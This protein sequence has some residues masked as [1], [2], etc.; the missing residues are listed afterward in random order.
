MHIASHHFHR[1][2]ALHAACLLCAVSSL[3]FAASDTDAET[4]NT[5][6][7][8]E[9]EMTNAVDKATSAF[10]FV[11]YGSGI[12]ISPDGYILSNHHVA[13][14]RSQW[15]VRVFGTRKYY[16]CDLAGTDPVGDLCLLKAR[17][18][19]KLPYVEFGE[20]AALKVGQQCFTIGD[21]FKLADP[22]DGPPAVSLGTIS[23]LHRFQQYY[24]D[25][26]Q[27]DAAINPGNSGGPL[28]TLDGK[29]IGITGQIMVRFGAR[30]NT[31]I[32][33]SIPV[34]QIKRFVEPLKAARGGIVYHGRLPN[35][36]AFAQ[37]KLYDERQGIGSE[38]FADTQKAVVNSVEPGS[39]AENF[40]FQAGDTVLSVDNIPVLNQWRLKG[41]VQSYLEGTQV[42]IKVL[43]NDRPVQLQFRL[44]RMLPFVAAQIPE[45]GLDVDP[46]VAGNGLHVSRVVASG[47]AERA[48]VQPD[49]VIVMVDG[50]PPVYRWQFD[51]LKKPVGSQVSIEIRRS[52]GT[53]IVPRTLTMVR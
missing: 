27:T 36:M 13:G 46:A 44:P 31:G 17:T 26:I 49:D 11:G 7:R 38:I 52:T 6:L 12:V 51:V 19:E 43:R 18:S 30:S 37:S 40:H 14:E 53:G 3:A 22:L 21:P 45:L 48:G 23:A 16:V 10:A 41:I 50:K 20:I 9:A 25:A 28:V 32:G 15:T 24:S 2:A 47:L 4:L 34:D 5:A 33:Y 1:L 39:E 42:S 29:L 8:I 35:G